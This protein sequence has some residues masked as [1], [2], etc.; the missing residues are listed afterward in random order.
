MTSQQESAL[1]AANAVR[2]ARREL[3]ESV[4]S[5]EAIL[6]DHLIDPPP[7]IVKMP[8][9]E[10]LQWIPRIGK[11][12]ARIILRSVRPPIDPQATLSSLSMERRL[13][14]AAAIDSPRTLE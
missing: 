3:R 5:R 12:R 7:F 2:S 9:V 4:K 14:L 8:V 1:L 13:A 10:L 11:D 6:H